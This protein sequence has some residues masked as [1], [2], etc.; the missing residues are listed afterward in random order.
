[1]FDTLYRRLPEVASAR[2]VAERCM[3]LMLVVGKCRKIL[4]VVGGLTTTTC[5]KRSGQSDGDHEAR[6]L[7]NS[8]AEGETCSK[9]SLC[10]YAP[11]RVQQCLGRR[12]SSFLLIVSPCVDW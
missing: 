4:V 9:S 3:V 6:L 2:R 1:M 12:M 10:G 5:T 7:F 11:M 8:V